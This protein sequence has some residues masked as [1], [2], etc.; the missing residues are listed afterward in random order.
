VHEAGRPTEAGRRLRDDVELATDRQERAL[1]EALGDD[2]DEL[3]GLLAPWA[4]AVVAG[5]GAQ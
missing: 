5:A 4:R 2:V 3:F 1:V